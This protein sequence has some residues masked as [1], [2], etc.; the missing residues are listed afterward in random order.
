MLAS[1]DTAQHAWQR[2]AGSYQ[3]QLGHSA[4]EFEGS[5]MID[6]PAGTC[7]FSNCSAPP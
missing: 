4:A 2:A 6:L 7:T 3:V 1:Y 5:A